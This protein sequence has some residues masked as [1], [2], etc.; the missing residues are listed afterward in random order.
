LLGWAKPVPYNPSALYKDFKYG[1][2]K[3]A[4]A[5]PLSNIA[6]AVIFAIMIRVGLGFFEPIVI[7]LLS[8]VV[9]LNCILAIFNLLPIPP[10]DG[11]KIL[12]AFLPHRYAAMIESIGLNGLIFTIF[13][14]YLFSGVIWSL[15][16][17]LFMVLVGGDAVSIF[18]TFNA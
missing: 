18:S 6:L 4:A 11:S 1:S 10:L 12:A 14:L 15:A 16:V 8:L 2:L 17:F 7:Y 9:L 13:F 3:V 5:G